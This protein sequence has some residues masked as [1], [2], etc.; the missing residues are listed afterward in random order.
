MAYFDTIYLVSGDSKPEIN[1]T[2]RDSHSAVPGKV[3]D[4]ENPET[5]LPIDITG[6]LVQVKF[7]ALGQSEVLDTMTCGL[8]APYEE[9]KCFMQWNKTTLDVPA[10][11]YEG[12]IELIDAN[13]R[14]QTVFDKLK[15][16]IRA[17]FD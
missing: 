3:L 14:R 4:P 15:F 9:G 8:V 6:K 2:L 7:K 1:F 16:K 17:D 13:G 12:A 11:T 10:G 5:W